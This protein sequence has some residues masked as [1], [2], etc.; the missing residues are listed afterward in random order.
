MWRPASTPPQ[1][2]YTPFE[3]PKVELGMYVLKV[4]KV[5]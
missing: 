2:G 4:D 3:T 1:G 5:S